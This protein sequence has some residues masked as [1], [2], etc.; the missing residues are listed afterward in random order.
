MS[1]RES[2][3]HKEIIETNKLVPQRSTRTTKIREINILMNLIRHVFRFVVYRFNII[4]I[5]NSLVIQR[6]LK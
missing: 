5:Y 4:K 3:R 6:E 1:T 2:P